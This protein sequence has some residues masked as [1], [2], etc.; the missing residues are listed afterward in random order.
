LPTTK[1]EK[2]MKVFCNRNGLQLGAIRWMYDGKRIDREKSLA[3]NGIEDDGEEI[4]MSGLIE[5]H[6]GAH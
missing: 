4:V 3:E 6:G 2:L 1:A 5:Q